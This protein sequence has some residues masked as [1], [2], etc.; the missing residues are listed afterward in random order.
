[1]Q[2]F[3]VINTFI[4]NLLPFAIHRTLRRKCKN[5]GLLHPVILKQIVKCIIIQ[6]KKHLLCLR[7]TISNIITRNTVMLA[8]TSL[9]NSNNNH[10]NNNRLL[11]RFSY[12]LQLWLHCTERTI[13]KQA[14]RHS[15]LITISYK[16]QAVKCKMKPNGYNNY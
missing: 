16:F 8:A 14:L 4:L 12:T 9:F 10:N 7:S 13:K 6:K 2:I 1:M 11:S 15:F 5:N 3:L